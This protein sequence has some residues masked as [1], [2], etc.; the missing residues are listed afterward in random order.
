MGRAGVEP[1]IAERVVG[2]VVGNAAQRI[3]DRGTYDEPKGFALAALAKLI[4]DIINGTPHK[5][6]PIRRKAKAG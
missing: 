6:V 1:H 4:E 3:Y 5:V 2:H